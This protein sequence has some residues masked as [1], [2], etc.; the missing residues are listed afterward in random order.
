MQAWWGMHWRRAGIGKV[1]SRDAKKRRRIAWYAS[2]TAPCFQKICSR[3]FI[4]PLTMRGGRGRL[5]LGDVY[6]N[7]GQPIV[8]IIRE[9]HPSM[10]VPPGENSM[11]TYKEVP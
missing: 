2:S 5:L 6:T 4:G 10:S 7:T 8:D 9:K 1:A 3:R 11:C